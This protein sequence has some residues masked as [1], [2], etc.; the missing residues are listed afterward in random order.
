MKKFTIGLLMAALLP[1][2]VYA[3]RIQ[4]K[5]GR[6]VVAVTAAGDENVLV[7]WRKLAQEPENC[8]YNL[9]RRGQ[10]STE[11]TKV[12]ST[13]ISLTN[14]Q[15]SKTQVPSGS[16]LAVT[17]VSPDGTE[18]EKSKPFLF[19]EHEWSNVFLDIDF[20]TK[21]LNPNDYRVVFARPLD[22]D[23]NGE[24]DA[25][26]VDRMCA[27]SDKQ[28]TATDPNT[29]TK[30]QMY[31]FDGE[32]LWTL[33]AGPN[34]SYDEGQNDKIVVYDINCDG[35]CEVIVKST[36]GTRF[37]DSKNNTWGKYANGKS[38]PD[39]DGDGIVDYTKQDKRNPPFYI[40][41]LDARTGEEIVCN[42]LDYSAI[43]D[44]QDAYSRDNRA[45]YYDDNEGKE[46]AFLTAKF[47]ICYFDGIHPSLAVQC[48]NRNKKTGHHY[49]VCE[50]KFDWAGGKPTNWHHAYTWSM[51]N[52][53]PA[54]A[55]FHQ[56]RVCDVDGDGIDEVMEGGYAVNSTKGMV[57][58]PGIGHGDRFDVSDIDPDRPG[59]EVYAIQQSNLLGQLIYD[60][61]TGEHIYEWYLP[62]IGDVGRGR[63]I[64]VDPDH[65]GYEVFSTMGNLYDCKGNVIK[66]GETA[67]PVEAVWWDGDLQRELIGS[68]GG[69]GYGTNVMV[70]KYD[71]TR[72]IQFSRESDWTVHAGGAVRPAFMG[73]MIGDWREEL[74]LMKQ[75]DQTST[76]L[77]G[78]S[79]NIPTEYSMYTLQEDPHYRLDCTTRG[80]YQMPCTGFYLGGDMPYP[81][82]PPV[83][84]ADLRW[85]GGGTWSTQ[86]AGFTTF[87]M[88]SAQN[89]ADGKSVIFDLS[90]DNSQTIQLSGT[91]KPSVVYLMPTK[92]H[93]YTFGGTGSLAGAM[94][95]WKSQ[96]GTA[97]FNGSLSYT[98]RTVIS[99]GTL[100]VN[101]AIAGPVELR[102]KGTLAG[103]CTV[104]GDMA[105]EEA[106]N[107]EGC[108]LMPGNADDKFGVMTFAKSLTL[109]G[110]VYVEINAADGKAGKIVVN[111]DLTLEGTNTFT[112]DH[113][114]GKLAAGDYVLAECTGTLTADPSAI[115]VRGLD[116]VK[117]SIAVKGKQLVLTA[118]DTRAAQ[119]D[120]VWTGN[121][122]NEWNYQAENF[123]IKDEATAFVAN[124]SVVFNDVSANRNISVAD[125]VVT[126]GVTFDFD[127]GTYTFSGEGGIAGEGG[128][129]KNGKGEVRMELRNNSY[130]GST[131]V[132]EG[133][134]T[135][136]SLADCGKNSSIGAAES[137]LNKLLLN[138]GTLKVEGTNMA[139]NQV[140]TLQD[141]STINVA[142]ASGTIS[143]KGMVY[144]SG[145]L[146]K[147]GPGQL[148]FIYGGTNPFAGM[149]VKQGKIA[150]GSWNSTFGRVGSPMVLAGGTVDLLD[151]NNSETRPVFDYDVTVVEGTNSTVMGTTRGAINGKFKGK[152]GLTIVST[153][154]RND[155]GAD[156]SAFEGT[157]TAQGENFRL[158][159]NVTDMGM[160][161]MVLDDG[162]KVGHYSSNGG[163]TKAVTTKI[164]SVESKAEDCNLGNGWKNDDGKV[165]KGVD[166]YEVGGNGASTTFAGRLYAKTIT[167]VGDGTWTIDNEESTSDIVVNGGALLL[168]NRP[169]GIAP[170]AITTGTITVNRG[171]RL[172]GTGGGSKIVVNEGGVISAGKESGYGTLKATGDVTLAKGSTIE[173]KLGQNAS[174]SGT[175]GKYNFAGKVTHSGDTILV[176]ID[177]A[178]ILQAGEEVEVFTGD[179]AQS[180]TFVVKTNCPNQAIEWDSSA[181]LTEGVLRVKSVVVGIKDVTVNGG[182]VDVYSVDGVKLRNDV[183]RSSALDGLAPGVYIVDGEKLVK[184]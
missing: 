145:V 152:G 126:G 31:T 14:Y 39:T 33:D 182:K 129:T 79:T 35:K 164:G 18:S 75:N 161:A 181:L 122:T 180:G 5:M 17:M 52:S 172:I 99:E 56:F 113:G 95:L 127:N 128:V 155:I 69:S 107:Y 148:N 40:S 67:Y 36:D 70:Q 57:M 77:I 116:G 140:V 154:V 42:E 134:L 74:I 38:D 139:T 64:D 20:E 21:I 19:N 147:D 146:V 71:G 60:A 115:V 23:G 119:K 162:A 45:D 168:N 61:A 102:A 117:Y 184:E 108:R 6:A 101:G 4:Q 151:V 125:N 12:N 103:V 28:P 178:R 138:G 158:M 83:M 171:G 82:L 47:A 81:P 37:W 153:G 10:G 7:S 109:P 51:R 105:F 150:T 86:G 136:T 170:S 114:D 29:N 72:L 142:S 97:T 8:T 132:N 30:L 90:G 133:T 44:G 48:Y 165:T 98:G 106:L 173:V 63:C 144:G 176:T 80:Y 9:Y 22:L 73:D 58:S 179:G 118:E 112:I 92:G 120:V 174:G 124:D 2:G 87:D 143:L 43:N 93:D 141:T 130:T 32:C 123:S 46:Y 62:T 91:L 157:L 104:N 50:W 55:E 167:K 66:E 15:V 169:Y 11:Y 159:D 68:S 78:Y 94:G 175:G 65:K 85:Q 156:F 110:E 1:S 149:I 54:A 16:E 111:G 25:V 13:P 177:P 84:V 100:C 76:G 137:G 41:I 24:Y 49:Y 59:L 160:T 166:A 26:L 135:V 3:Q 163:N 89:Y 183:D 27:N 121:E 34:Q 131:I 88:T 53:A 96:Q